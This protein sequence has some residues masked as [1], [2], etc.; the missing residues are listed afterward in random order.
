MPSTPAA[1]STPVTVGI[2]VAKA[3]LDVA[4]RPREE[5]WAVPN[6][7]GGIA[8][9][10]ARLAP[11]APALVVLEATGGLEV[12]AAAA[13]AEAGLPVAVVNPRQVRDFARAVGQLAKTDALD[14]Q[15]LA[16]F[17]A[18]VRPAPRPLPDADTQALAALVARRRQVLALLT[19]ERQRLGTA[20]VPVRARVRAPV[21][22]LEQELADL[23]DD[24]RRR[25]RASPIWR[26]KEDRLRSVPG[27]GPV[28]ATALLA[29]LPE[30]GALDR[31]RLAAL[32]GV[33]P[34][35][36]DSGTRRGKRLVW[37]GRGRVR[38][39]LYMAALV[40]VRH[41][42]LL[43]AFYARLLR[44]GKAKQ[45]ALTAC[46]HKLLLI[47]NAIVRASAPWRQPATAAG[48]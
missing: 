9:L 43:R 5:A 16:R 39:A 45:V 36:R 12:P 32:V 2:D 29:A 11:L 13:L 48:A 20:R 3:R 41:N 44:G 15:V 31:K 40:A 10:V 8:S 6:D 35:N 7:E 25:V 1:P 47:L 30:R 28:V 22:W 24:L 18:V 38:T 17:G 34:L 26:T 42:P 23:D 46:M 37:G 33:A 19:A 27:S 14:A 21:A 4:V